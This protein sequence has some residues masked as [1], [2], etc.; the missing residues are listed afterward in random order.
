[1]REGET[2]TGRFYCPNC[3]V[4][5]VYDPD[6]FESH[7]RERI[8]HEEEPRSSLSGMTEAE[9][10]ASPL[11]SIAITISVI[12]VLFIGGVFLTIPGFIVA[13]VAW[14]QKEPKGKYAAV[15]CGAVLI[16]NIL[17]W[18]GLTVLLSR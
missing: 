11:S 16:V 13:V 18:T 14:T 6:R 5:I 1:M 10:K 4:M 8:K 3:Q 9:K 15:I 17:I 7:L 2:V 12:G